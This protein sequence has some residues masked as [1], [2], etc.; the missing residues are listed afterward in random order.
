M[1]GEGR[2]PDT[3]PGHEAA[4]SLPPTAL[5]EQPR[6]LEPPV[7]VR[8]WVVRARHGWVQL[9][10]VANAYTRSAGHVRYTD[11]HGRHGACWVWAGAIS[12]R[13]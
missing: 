13:Q 4:L 12:R 6:A 2:H 8:V 10:G 9:D 7:P 11:E 5:G 3:V 1:T